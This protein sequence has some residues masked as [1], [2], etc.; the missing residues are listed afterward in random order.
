[1]GWLVM[2]VASVSRVAITRSIPSGTRE[3]IGENPERLRKRH[4]LSSND[5]DSRITQKPQQI[6]CSADESLRH[7]IQHVPARRHEPLGQKITPSAQ[8]LPHPVDDQSR[9]NE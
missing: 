9:R 4:E 8:N 7:P 3:H 6:R 2:K 5:R 1:M